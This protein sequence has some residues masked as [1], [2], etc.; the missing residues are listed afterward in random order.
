MFSVS[1]DFKYLLY[2]NQ[3]YDI[4]ENRVLREEEMTYNFWVNFIK[5]NLVSSYVHEIMDEIK[6][7]SIIREI[8]TKFSRNISEGFN[9]VHT[10][11]VERALSIDLTKEN[12]SEVVEESFKLMNIDNLLTEAE[13]NEAWY[14]DWDDFKGAV[15]GTAS[16]AWEGAKNL[17]KKSWNWL[18]EKGI[19]SF[20]E[21]LRSALFSWGGIA[22]TA[23]LSATGV[24]TGGIG[25]AL[26]MIVWG[27]MLIY[28]VADAL[29][30]SDYSFGKVFNIFIDIIGVTT[31][32]NG[33]SAVAKTAGTN[34]AKL[35][36]KGAAEAASK[37]VATKGLSGKIIEVFAALKSTKVGQIVGRAVTWLTTKLTGLFRRLTQA[38]KWFK[39]N[40]GST[41]LYR[42]MTKVK[43]FLQTI[44]SGL[45]QIFTTTK[46]SARTASTNFKRG[47]SQKLQAKGVGAT[48]SQEMARG[49]KTGIVQGGLTAGL[50]HAVGG[51]NSA[52]GDGGE[53]AMKVRREK[54]LSKM[55]PEDRERAELEDEGINP[56]ALYDYL[57]MDRN[58]QNSQD[59]Q[60]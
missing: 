16:A 42:G 48:A 56:D 6:V 11:K 41:F 20:F 45:K 40:F 52:F 46:N 5:E 13:F 30:E 55:S 49:L 44:G 24:A 27:A 3:V 9:T 60:A 7:K 19:D 54:E 12:V 35:A 4:K 28:D 36:T 21:G 51:D 22:I 15:S 53:M 47:V 25:P 34:T 43:N 39:D 26:V 57:E 17:G 33:A 23:F 38:A 18:K 1:H 32:G 29:S 10:V 37:G 58:N 14:S 2:E 31:A 50:I 59:N 8:T